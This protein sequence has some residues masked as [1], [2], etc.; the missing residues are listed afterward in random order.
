MYTAE[1]IL[2]LWSHLDKYVTVRE[3][4]QGAVPALKAAEIFKENERCMS[5]VAPE[6]IWGYVL[7]GVKISGGA[8]Q[9]RRRTWETTRS[10]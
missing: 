2:R 4:A 6:R 8:Q 9:D 3:G 7:Y 1:P 5:E 10:K